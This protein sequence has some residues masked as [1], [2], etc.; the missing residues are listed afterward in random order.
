MATG[1]EILEGKKVS[2]NIY[3]C[4]DGVYRWIY[5][6]PMAKNPTILITVW[7]VLPFLRAIY[8]VQTSG[9]PSTLSESMHC[10]MSS[11]GP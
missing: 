3:L 9:R 7:K 10:C 1:N 5:E 11:A 6:F 8:S 4:P 2:E